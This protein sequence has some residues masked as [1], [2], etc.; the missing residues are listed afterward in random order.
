[1]FMVWRLSVENY[2]LVYEEMK[3]QIDVIFSLSFIDSCRDKKG[4]VEKRENKMI[5]KFEIFEEFCY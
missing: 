1:M 3:V 5:G 2:V 4:R